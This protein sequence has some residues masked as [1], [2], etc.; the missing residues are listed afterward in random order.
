MI[1][2][3]LDIDWFFTDFSGRIGFVASAGGKIPNSI[4]EKYEDYNFVSPYF[5][6]LPDITDY[7][8]SDK[9]SMIDSDRILK[10]YNDFIHLARKGIYVFD[11]S[12]FN[13]HSNSVYHLVAKPK[14]DITIN[15]L[16]T[17]IIKTLKLTKFNLNLDDLQEIDVSLIK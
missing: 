6:S 10:Q 7:I 17:N 5:R 3:G 2:E 11:K 8:L 16:E 15:D 12:F 14:F 13:D 1:E 9:L 4:I